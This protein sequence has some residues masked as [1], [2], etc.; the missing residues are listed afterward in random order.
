MH[1]IGR[2]AGG[3]LPRYYGDI[4]Y[5]PERDYV[6]PIEVPEVPTYSDPAP[7]TAAPGA[8]DT[9]SEEEEEA[10]QLMVS[11]KEKEELSGV[12]AAIAK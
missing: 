9:S 11:E 4:R 12:A 1:I 7:S 6:P 2:V 8:A 3:N 5:K 10:L